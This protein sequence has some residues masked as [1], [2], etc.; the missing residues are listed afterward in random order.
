VDERNPPIRKG[1]SA[2]GAKSK[3]LMIAIMS[4]GPKPRFISDEILEPPLG[5]E[6]IVVVSISLVLNVCCDPW[7]VFGISAY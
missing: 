3:E 2:T 7:L 4:G 6:D 1:N 5:G